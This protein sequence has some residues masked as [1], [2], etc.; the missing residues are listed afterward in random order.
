MSEFFV[1]VS[2]LFMTSLIFV[3]IHYHRI[4]SANAN[5]DSDL[6][7]AAMTARQRSVLIT[8]TSAC[9]IGSALALA[10]ADRGFLTFATARDVSKIDGQLKDHD[11][12]HIVP[13]DVTSPK[14]IDYAYKAVVEMTDGKLDYLV[15]NAGTGYT[16][17]LA[18]FDEEKA[19]KVFDVNFWG[20]LNVTKVF[21]PSLVRAKGTVVNISSVGAVVH[22]PWIG[23]SIPKAR[24]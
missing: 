1:A 9:S 19:R 2:L 3:Y 5:V 13:L 6:T 20:V 4:K 7:T 23:K 16:T 12:V 15:N 21:M 10:F 18:E 22:T 24:F 14:S 8:G 17:P 11:K